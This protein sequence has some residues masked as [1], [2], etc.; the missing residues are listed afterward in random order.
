MLDAV[1]HRLGLGMLHL[2][3]RDDE[4]ASPVGSEDE[5]DRAL[6]WGEGEPR[7]VQDVIGIEEHDAR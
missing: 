5:R 4:G 6:G 2:E 3:A 1:E 7:V